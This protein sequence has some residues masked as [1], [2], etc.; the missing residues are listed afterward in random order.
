MLARTAGIA[1]AAAL[2][3]DLALKKSWKKCAQTG[4]SILA[5]TLPWSLW[6]QAQSNH[7]SAH[8]A[9]LKDIA[10]SLP[11]LLERLKDS[12]FFYAGRL[13]IHVFFPVAPL[14]PALFNIL[15]WGLAAA[16]A[17]C[18]LTALS[19]LH[20]AQENNRARALSFY[21]VFYLT[22]LLVWPRSDL[23]YLY[24]FLP[25]AG[26]LFFRIT[27]RFSRQGPKMAAV[28][29]LTA[30]ISLAT[31]LRATA[32][33]ILEI[34]RHQNPSVPVETLAWMKKNLPAHSVVASASAATV[35]FYA[36]FQGIEFPRVANPQELT[37]SL[38]QTRANFIL[39]EGSL[40]GW[41]PRMPPMDPTNW[42]PY[43]AQAI[44]T[45]RCCP[46]LYAN[47]TEK[48]WLYR[49]R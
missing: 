20:L 37:Q 5:V 17:V 4:A 35:Y 42:T 49:L 26:L 45:T 32:Q 10:W 28:C 39:L 34:R 3:A 2:L 14:E 15:L 29:A 25:I 48:T 38:R 18:V 43:V 40:L 44:Q 13:T 27:G 7:A 41:S 6:T 31:S 30:V 1:M 21:A 46:L 36:R 47:E 23:R 11:V 12:I 9:H 8:L 19:C 33:Q 16:F 22:I 24:P